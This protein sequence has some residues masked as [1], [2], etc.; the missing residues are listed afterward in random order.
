MDKEFAKDL[1]E[2]LSK[3]VEIGNWLLDC[4]KI[5]SGRSVQSWKE[6]KKRKIK[7]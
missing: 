3:I 1:Y 4:L 2:G 5:E 6:E 7:T